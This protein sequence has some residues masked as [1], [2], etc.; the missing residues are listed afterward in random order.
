[1]TA[2]HLKTAACKLWGAPTAKTADEWRFGTHGSKSIRFKDLVWHDHETQEGGGVVD[3]CARAGLDVSGDYGNTSQNKSETKET[4]YRYLDEQG[5]CLFE[6]V[7]LPGHKFFQ[8]KPDGTKNIKGVRRVLY[9]LPELLARKD[10][11]AFVTEGEKDADNVA[12]LGLIATTNP[13]GVGKW[14][15]EYCEFL[16]DR[17]VVILP[18]NDEVGREHAREVSN[19]LHGIARSVRVLMLPGLPDKGDVSD[20]IAAGGGEEDLLRLVAALD[21]AP[22]PATGWINLCSTNK[23]G[24]PIVNLENTLLGLRSDPSVKDRYSFNKMLVTPMIQQSDRRP[25][26]D[27]DITD[28]QEYLQIAGLKRLSRDTVRQA[29]IAYAGDRPYH[30]VR[31]YLEALEWDGIERT[32]LSYLGATETNYNKKVGTMFLISMV[33]RIFRPGCKV[34]YMLVLEGPQGVKKSMACRTLFTDEYFSDNLPD[35]STGK[36]VSV[37]LRGKWGIEV[38]ELHAFNKAESTLLKQF[39]SRQHERY[40]PPYGHM[41]VDEPRQCVF[42]GTTNKTKYLK[43]ETGGRRFWPII[44]GTIDIESL[45]RD[46][47]QLLAQ[48]VFEFRR[49]DPWWPDAEFEQKTIVHEQAKRYDQDAWFP[50]VQ[51]YLMTSPVSHIGTAAIAV[52]ALGMSTAHIDRGTQLRISN[53]MR[54]LEWE[55]NHTRKGNVWVRP[56]GFGEA[57]G[58]PCEPS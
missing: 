24:E 7:R 49:G 15:K 51:A 14:R 58:E 12:G 37:H 13:G 29:V 16:R 1:M 26:E 17:D 38:S 27:D 18:D 4:V 30:P 5:V 50:I 46:R 55:Q 41:E 28:L 33:A 53:I 40:R 34:D 45:T 9:R 2:D 47:D 11:P 6:V 56:A 20:W 31:E 25:L 21:E 39:V 3:L 35:I 48:A 52:S 19:H 44:T 22:A 42:I 8:R 57:D 32:F 10:L 43:D 54:E 23:A 36:D